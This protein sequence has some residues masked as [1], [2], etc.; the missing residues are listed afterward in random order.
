MCFTP[1]QYS[2]QLVSPSGALEER[3]LPAMYTLHSSSFRVLTVCCFS[4]NSYICHQMLLIPSMVFP[5]LFPC[6]E[7]GLKKMVQ[8]CLI[9]Q[10]K[11][12]TLTLI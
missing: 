4:I 5:S 8:Q 11:T 6:S 2:V 9:T 3:G 10:T 12:L 7:A 1:Y